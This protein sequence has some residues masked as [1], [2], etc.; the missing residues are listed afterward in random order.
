MPTAQYTFMLPEDQEE[1][2]MFRDGP[3]YH[4]AIWD[5]LQW[6]RG[7]LKHG[8]EKE[9]TLE[10]ARAKLWECLRDAGVDT[11]AL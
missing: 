11:D 4:T 10:E 3:K 6:M 5:Y 2:R 9:P 8:C 1:E 7:I